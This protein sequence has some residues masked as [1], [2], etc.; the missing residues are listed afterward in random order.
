M[1]ALVNSQGRVLAQASKRINQSLG[2]PGLLADFRTLAADLPKTKYKCIAIAS[3]GPLHPERGLLLHPTNFFTGEKSWGVLPLSAKLKGI[4]KKPVFLENDAAAAVLGESWKG[5][6]KRKQNIIVMTLGT[7][8][9]IGVMMNGQLLRAGQGLHSEASH[10]PINAEDLS[11]PCGCGAYGCIEAYL[12]GSGFA[13]ALGSRLGRELTGEDCLA[14]AKDGNTKALTM[15]A[16]Y[17]QKLAQAIRTLSVVFAP[18]TVVLAGGFAEA[19]PYFL[20]I[21]QRELPS[22][23]RRYRE[24]VDLLPKIQISKLGS[25]L[26][27]IGAANVALRKIKKRR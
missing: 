14:L 5:G 24:G 26:G 18:E 23:L 22:L 1:A 4:F 19:S 12:S 3:A 9:G 13:K 11:R 15:F 17:G 7:G 20:P 6:H 27:V 10:I 2:F 16:D 25:R 8:V 21:A